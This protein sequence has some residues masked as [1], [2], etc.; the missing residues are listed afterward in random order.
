LSTPDLPD[1][2][3]LRAVCERQGVSPDDDDLSAV[4]G[5][6]RAIVPALEELETRLADEPGLAP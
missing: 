2:D 5:F 6:L 4:Q 1:L 3:M